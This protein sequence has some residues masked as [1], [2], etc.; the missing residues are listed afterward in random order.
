MKLKY[1]ISI[2]VFLS[3]LNNVKA[4]LIEPRGIAGMQNLNNYLKWAVQDMRTLANS[5]FAP[6]IPWSRVTGSPFWNDNWRLASLYDKNDKIIATLPVRLNLNTSSV[7]FID[8]KG[9]ELS[10]DPDE[11]RKVVFLQDEI[12]GPGAVFISYVP[13]AYFGDAKNNNYLQVMNEGKASLLAYN[14]RY[15]GKGDSSSPGQQR[16]YYKNEVSYYMARNN[17]V[18]R[19]KKLG[20]EQIFMLLP[21]ANAFDEW[22]TE[23]KLN[24]KKEADIK[25]FIDYYNSEKK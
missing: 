17:K 21:G 2:A 1:F 11:I 3:V 9:E 24:M 4:Q 10:L 12:T 5:D 19:L 16:Y 7:H 18:E 14:R 6:G 23:N 22:V 15:V 13:N 8:Q 25:K 20:K